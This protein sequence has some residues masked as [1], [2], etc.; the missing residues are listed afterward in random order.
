MKELHDSSISDFINQKNVE[1][2]LPLWEYLNKFLQLDTSSRIGPALRCDFEGIIGSS[3]ELQEFKKRE[4]LFPEVLCSSPD[5]LEY[6]APYFT[7]VIR[8]VP[9]TDGF[10]EK[11]SNTEFKKIPTQ[12]VSASNAIIFKIPNKNHEIMKHH[13]RKF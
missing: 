7:I 3:E 4:S 9:D 2:S 13:V 8:L 10:V 1:E 12:S 6:Y 11:Q 5:N